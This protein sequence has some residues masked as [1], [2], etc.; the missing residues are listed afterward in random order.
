MPLPL[1]STEMD[2]VTLLPGRTSLL[3]VV[4]EMVAVLPGVGLEE[5]DVG[6]GVPKDDVGEA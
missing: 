2:I 1:G 4:I 6:A 5:V 3:F